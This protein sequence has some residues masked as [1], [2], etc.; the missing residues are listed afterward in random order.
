MHF[1]RGH[2]I[3]IELIRLLSEEY[4]PDAIAEVMNRVCGLVA[5]NPNSNKCGDVKLLP[6]R[7]FHPVAAMF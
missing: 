6:H 7:Y 3:K 1:E 4:D 5:G 2:Q